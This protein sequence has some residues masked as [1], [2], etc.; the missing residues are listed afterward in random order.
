MAE[1]TQI[2]LSIAN[3][4]VPDTMD[5]LCRNG[6]YDPVVHGPD[7]VAFAISRLAQILD[8]IV[9]QYRSSRPEAGIDIRRG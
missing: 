7:R 3:K 5:A 2:P 1:R 6:D 4:D 8:A 9:R